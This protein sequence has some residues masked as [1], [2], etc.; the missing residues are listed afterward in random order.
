MA[1]RRGGVLLRPI[2]INIIL[3]N[4][5]GQG[6]AEPYPYETTIIFYN[7]DDKRI[8]SRR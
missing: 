4:A 3:L 2:G 5:N 8:S 6:R 1:T 7:Y